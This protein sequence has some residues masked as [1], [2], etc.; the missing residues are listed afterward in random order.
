MANILLHE[1][2]IPIP[3]VKKKVIYHLGD[4]HLTAI[5]ALCTAEEIAFAKEKE[6]NW[7]RARESFA[8]VHGEP[9]GEDRNASANVHFANMLSAA[10]DGDALLMT[11]DVIDYVSD[12]NMRKMEE[13]LSSLPLPVMTV[14]GNHEPK[15]KLPDGYLYA[16]CKLPVQILDL[17]DLFILGLDDSLREITSVQTKA[18]ES[19]LETGKHIVIA[20]HVPILPENASGPLLDCGE[21]FHLNY[22]GASDETLRFVELVKANAGQIAAVFVGH[23]HFLNVSLLSPGLKQYTTSQG[24]VGNLNRYVIGE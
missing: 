14:C 23:V 17:G 21:Y 13:V 18:L 4:V 22:S 8:S 19:L 3:G 10:A 1:Y 15:E 12:A 7:L 6:E 5:D 11:G 2:K 24:L 20:M 9:Y 16:K